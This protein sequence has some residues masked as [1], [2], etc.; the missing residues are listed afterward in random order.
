MGR[1]TWRWVSAFVLAIVLTTTVAGQTAANNVGATRAEDDQRTTTANDLKPSPECGAISLTVKI[2]G[3]TGGNGNDLLTGS[4]AGESMD[5]GQGNDC[6]LGGGGNDN[7]RG[8]GGT[9]VCIGG[10]GTDTFHPSCETQ[11]Q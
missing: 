10:A 7:L 5:G 2:T 9:D 11:I 1:H 6:I 4:G 8:S 3:T